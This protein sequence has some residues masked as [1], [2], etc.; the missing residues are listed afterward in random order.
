MKE[1]RYFYVP[2][3]ADRCE[4]PADEATHAVR[5]LRLKT[6]DE[7]FLMDGKGSFY[8]AQVTIATN[9]HCG[10]AI[11]E[12]MPQHKAWCGRIHL[13]IAPTKDL[14]RIEW[15]A[16]KATEVGFDEIS[17][18]DCRFSERRQMR[19]DRI[20]RI[21]VA[22]MKQSRKPWLPKVNAMQSFDD[23]INSHQSGL[24]Y[25]CHCY[26]E[27]ERADFFSSLQGEDDQE[28]IIL[29]GP[30]GDFSIEE[31]RKAIDN[32]YISTTLGTARLRTETA[33]LSAVMMAN[34]VLRKE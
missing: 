6:D 30:E 4:L 17:F 20:E 16:E 21:V 5:V 31:V 23:F 7:I 33:G 27:I 1:T 34:L 22:A 3:A 14:G 12:S 15:M 18:L 10:Y 9:H 11:Q 24:R 25:I 28:V 8:R 29:V 19:E 32:G 26:N 2:D 13:A